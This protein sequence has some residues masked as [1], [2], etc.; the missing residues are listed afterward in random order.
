MELSLLAFRSY[1][2]SIPSRSLD[3]GNRELKPIRRQNVPYTVILNTYQKNDG[4]RSIF[5]KLIPE[6]I[7]L[8]L[9]KKYRK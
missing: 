6:K 4:Q 2:L 1:L 5:L 8:F 3:K 7:L 9:D